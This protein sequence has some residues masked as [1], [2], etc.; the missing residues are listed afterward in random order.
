[1]L[2][3][4]EPGDPIVGFRHVRA[5]ANEI[6][7]YRLLHDQTTGTITVDHAVDFVALARACGVDGLTAKAAA[8]AKF[9]TDKPSRAQIE[10]ARR[11]LD[12]LT[13]D[14]WLVCVEGTKGGGDAKHPSAWF[15]A[16]GTVIG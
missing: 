4:G 16:T 12:K 6:G 3:T 1:M 15:P 11:S 14:G 9:D 13:A 5:P 2:L 7:P 10:K 8:A